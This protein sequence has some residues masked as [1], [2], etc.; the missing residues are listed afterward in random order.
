MFREPR[1][2][3]AEMETLARYRLATKAGDRIAAE[4]A[5]RRLSNICAAHRRWDEAR[6]HTRKAA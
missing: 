1:W 3:P 5:F 2:W 4:H 6:S